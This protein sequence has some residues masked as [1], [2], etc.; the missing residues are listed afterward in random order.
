MRFTHSRS[1]AAAAVL[2]SAALAAGCA[3]LS[4]NSLPKAENP[5]AVG[6]LA[7]IVVFVGNVANGESGTSAEGTTIGVGGTVYFTA[8]GRDMNQKFVHV[9]PKWTASK[10]EVVEIKPS[11]GDV[12]AVKGLREGSTQ[13]VV[14]DGGVSQTLNYIFVH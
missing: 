12:A 4:K 9:K 2:V 1:S 3:G 13:I 10:P 14:E 6:P 8:Q 7:R 5:L 11:E